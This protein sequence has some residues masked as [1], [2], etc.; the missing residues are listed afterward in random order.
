MSMRPRLFVTRE[1]P[2]DA[3]KRLS[4]YYSVTVWRDPSPPPKDILI[5][6]VKEVDA[7]AC[8]LTD[9]IDKELL[10]KADKLRIV[11]QYAVGYDNIDVAYATE[12]GIYVTNTPGVL[13]DSTADLTFALILTAARRIIEAHDYVVKGKW[14]EEGVAWHPSLML[15]I[16]LRGKVLGIVGMGRIGKAVARRAM[17]FGMNVVYYDRKRLTPEE[18]KELSV[19]YVPFEELLSISDIISVHVPLTPET[20]HMFKLEQFKMMKRTAIFIN[21]SRGSVV[22][23]EDLVKA[24]EEKL[25]WAAGLDVFEEEPLPKG[26]PLTTLSNVVLAPHIG[27]ATWEAR[28]AMANA[29]A[30][31]LIAFYRGEIPPN[32]VNLDVTK[33]RRPGFW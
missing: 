7:L 6:E 9:K 26:H 5:S 11:A 10:E 15:G 4:S 14:W 23:T 20:K 3:I 2:G 30:D 31:N 13:T 21:T 8:L 24:L 18:E 32:L 19:R 29:V 1:L 28:T 25:I 22:K 27:S 16:E 17:G 33:I 12:K